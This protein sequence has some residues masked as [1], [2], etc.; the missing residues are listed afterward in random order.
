MTVLLMVGV[1]P[2]LLSGAGQIPLLLRLFHPELGRAVEFETGTMHWWSEV[3][4]TDVVVSDLSVAMDEKSAIPMLTVDAV[5]TRQP[6]WKLALSASRDIELRIHRPTLNVRVFDGTSNLEQTIRKLFPDNHISGETGVPAATF[7]VT[8]GRVRLLSEGRTSTAVTALSAISGQYA[9]GSSTPGLPRISV[10]ACFGE[11]AAGA[12]DQHTARYPEGVDPRI[13]A[14]LND[15]AGDYPQQPL[16][17][18]RLKSPTGAAFRPAFSLQLGA[19]EGSGDSQQLTIE[20]R[21]LDLADL[22]PVIHRFLPDAVCRGTCSCRLQARILESTAGQGIAGRIQF[23]GEAVQWRQASWAADEFLDLDTITARGAVAVAADGILL[24]GLRVQSGIFNMDGDGEVRLSPADRVTQIHAVNGQQTRQRQSAVSEATAAA[25]GQVHLNGS[26]DL[27]AVCGMIPQTLKVSDDVVVDSGSLRFSCR[28]QR[29]SPTAAMTSGKQKHGTQLQWQLLAETSLIQASRAGQPIT[30]KSPMRVTAVGLARPGRVYMRRAKIDGNFGS[31]MADPVEGGIAVRGTFSP[32][33]LWQDVRH[34]TQLPQPQIAG[35]V[36][37][38]VDVRR[39]GDVLNLHNVL[40]EASEVSVRSR[41]LTADLSRDLLQMMD[42]RLMVEGTTAAIKTMVSP[43]HQMPWLSENSRLV[44]SL[45]AQPDQRLTLQ[46]E[47]RRYKQ[48]AR[49]ESGVSEGRVD[50]SIIADRKTGAFVVERGL[51]ELP[52]LRSKI[53]GTLAVRHGLLT[54][55]L[56]ADTSYDLASLSTQVSGIPNAAVSVSG[57]GRDTFSVRGAPSLLTEA[58]V[59]RFLARHVDSAKSDTLSITPISASGRIA[60]QGGKLYGLS[61]GP[62][63]AAVELKSGR[64]RTDPIHCTV[65]SGQ[66]DVMPQWD[67]AANRLQLAPGSR[68]QNLSLTEELC[69]EWL[70][71][72]APMMA[73]ATSVQGRF[74]AR[75]HRFD[76]DFGQPE[77]SMVQAMLT[78]HSATAAPGPSLGQLFQLV[79]LLRKRNS[80]GTVTIELPSQGIPFEIRDGMVVHDGLEVVAGGYY[81]TSRGGVGFNRELRLALEVPLEQNGN[82]REN[83]VRVPIL[84]TIDRPLLDTSGL[85]QN[86]GKQ[87]IGNRIDEQIDRGLNG[88]LD[89]LQ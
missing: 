64:L 76:Y 63:A 51:V 85:L 15:L 75:V 3:R 86:V 43:W 34:L 22:R 9:N 5:A 36:R 52:G 2:T 56:S 25:A 65:G 44:A 17:A 39:D 78:V 57:Q 80:S 82:G 66:V 89:K 26:I 77:Q 18:G 61:I 35:E 69:D 60:W 72:V 21:Q 50:V 29:A 11:S 48:T 58:D 67:I 20:A 71:Y 19:P 10:T 16:R 27:A 23:L 59:V 74:S 83:S 31:I 33:R 38:E 84:G 68:L 1:A 49:P 37:L 88:L 7:T 14:T 53:T 70:G 6:L 40:L 79:S 81:M 55:H 41:L 87:Q 32:L 24:Q 47:L 13:A 54:V 46:A 30:V 12:A 45:N 4:L 28:M 62:G 42:G 8:E 73:E